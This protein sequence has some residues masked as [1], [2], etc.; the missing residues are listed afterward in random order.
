MLRYKQPVRVI[1]CTLK[2]MMAIKK[3]KLNVGV[4]RQF[5]TQLFS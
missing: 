1:P 2:Y 3:K 5:V 4:R